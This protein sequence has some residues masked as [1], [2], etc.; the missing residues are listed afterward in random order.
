MSFSGHLGKLIT[1][2]KDFPS[3][4]SSSFNISLSKVD[5]PEPL[6]PT[7]NANSPL[8]MVRF[9]NY[10]TPMYRLVS[11]WNSSILYHVDLL[12]VNRPDFGPVHF[13]FVQYF[14]LQ[15]FILLIYFFAIAD[16][17]NKDISKQ[18]LTVSNTKI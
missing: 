10:S 8:F 14:S 9:D 5:L 7:K 17:T 1:V 4:G 16:K 11:F 18:V 15:Y 12:K 6:G 3:V 2:Y 13:S